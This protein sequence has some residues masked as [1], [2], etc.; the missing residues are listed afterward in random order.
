MFRQF[1][2]TVFLIMSLCFVNAF[3][4]DDQPAP[5][6]AA[7]PLLPKPFKLKGINVTGSIRTR[8]E[9]WNW[10][11][12]T[13]GD[14]TYTYSGN[15]FR[16]M[17][18]QSRE[19]FGWQVEFAA[20]VLLGLPENATGMGAQGALGLGANYFTANNRSRNSA[21]LFPK[22]ALIFIQGLGGKSALLKVG[23]FEFADGSE[24][25]PKNATLS[26][27]KTTR[28]NMRLLGHF[29]WAHVGRSFDGIH[30]SRN[31]A[32]ARSNITFVGAVPTRGVF[33][34]DGW[35]WNQV[36]FG[37][38]SYTKAWAQGRHAAETRL[39]A[40]YYDDWRNVLKVDNRPAP[41]R[42]ADK[43]NLKITTFGGHSI[44]ALDTK[45]ATYD[46]L[47]WGA[48]QTGRWGNL[49]HRAY[50]VIG[51]AGVQPKAL[52]TLKWKPWLRSGL[53]LSSGDGNPGDT[54]HN[55]FF[56]VMPTPRPFARFPFFNMMNNQDIY[57]GITVK[58][59]ARLSLS[60]EFHS[61]SLRNRNDL[62]YAGGGVFQPWTFGYQGRATSGAKSLANLY[63]VGTDIKINPVTSLNL[64][65]GRAQGL[66]AI[67]AIYPKGQSG[68]LGYVELLFRF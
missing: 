37:Y 7:K 68:N 51:E 54:K 21:M 14:P 49:D 66:A 41:V 39:F 50:A 8:L 46:L 25:A 32:D 33:Q 17:L 18:S 60:S 42:N 67:A 61:L 45:K 36:A 43:G 5:F 34:A 4:E 6:K 22:Q 44:H 30:Y 65:Y 48:A 13:T 20:P 16:L 40:L 23:R 24:M 63:D 62:W 15:I 3:A 27:L 64:Y 28:I 53:S 19:S 12:P 9:S 59:H 29:G 1:I 11:E 35:G 52:A 47:F 26:T 58:P 31:T 55:S 38:L 2:Q 10:F 57:A 56:Q